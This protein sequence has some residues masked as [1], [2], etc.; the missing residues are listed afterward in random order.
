MDDH[1][2]WAARLYPLAG[3]VVFLPLVVYRDGL[4][5]AYPYIELLE[6]TAKSAGRAWLRLCPE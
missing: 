2:R 6:A 5:Y 4:S 3:V 1:L